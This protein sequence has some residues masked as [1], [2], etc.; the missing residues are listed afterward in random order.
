M[1]LY[2][3]GC[4]GGRRDLAC[5]S[6]PW[7]HRHGAH[8]NQRK[9][10]S[11]KG[12]IKADRWAKSG[13]IVYFHVL[14]NTKC[15]VRQS[16]KLY[17]AITCMIKAI[18]SAIYPQR[19]KIRLESGVFCLRTR[20]AMTSR[21]SPRRKSRPN[22]RDVKWSKWFYKKNGGKLWTVSMRT[23]CCNRRFVPFYAQTN[24]LLVSFF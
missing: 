15:N 3:V 5:S 13:D 9:P 2:G 8:H 24:A 21:L 1:L 4:T 17:V 14:G 10:P 19:R 18:R 12:I 11:F 20:E 23:K 16:N 6:S 22:C 7:N